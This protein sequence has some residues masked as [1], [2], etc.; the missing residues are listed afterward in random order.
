MYIGVLHITIDSYTEIHRCVH[1]YC[2]QMCVHYIHIYAQV[3]L[4]TYIYTC[5]HT[6]TFMYPVTVLRNIEKKN[7]LI[8][9]SLRAVE[10]PTLPKGR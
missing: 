5:M 1:T 7:L 9:D 8:A 2:C 3:F 4:P 6:Y 10:Q